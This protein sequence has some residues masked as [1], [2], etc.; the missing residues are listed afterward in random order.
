MTMLINNWFKKMFT[1]H[2]SSNVGLKTSSSYSKD[3]NTIPGQHININRN[4]LLGEIITDR[5]TIV[6]KPST[7]SDADAMHCDDEQNENRNILQK[8]PTEIKPLKKDTIV[9]DK[10]QACFIDCTCQCEV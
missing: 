2:A 5:C 7:M 1:H 4:C 6:D 3:I 9:I 10:F 8:I